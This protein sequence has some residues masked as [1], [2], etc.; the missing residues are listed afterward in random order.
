MLGG[1]FIVNPSM[2]LDGIKEFFILPSIKRR[3]KGDRLPVVFVT[4]LE[5]VFIECY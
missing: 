3:V 4:T 1:A 5:V 2:L